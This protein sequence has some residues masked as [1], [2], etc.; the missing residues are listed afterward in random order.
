M[1]ASRWVSGALSLAAVGL[2]WSLLAESPGNRPWPQFRGPQSGGVDDSEPLPISW[3]VESGTNIR[4]QTP[5]P[6][7]AHASPIIWGDRVYLTTA[8]KPG[9]S[10]LKVGL[11]GD[12]D[13]VNETEP[14]QWRLLAL[15]RLTGSVVWNVLG[16]E[17]IPRVKRHTKATHCNSTPATDGKRI[18]TATA[19]RSAR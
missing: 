17:S 15:D 16:N 10:E 11:Y 3:D 8:V 18:V 13:S 6:G 4:W 9:K 2:T 1:K 12:I 14:Q 19:L 5:S 7:L